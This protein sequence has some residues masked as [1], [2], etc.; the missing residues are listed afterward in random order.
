MPV[1]SS[2]TLG[3]VPAESRSWSWSAATATGPGRRPSR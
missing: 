1:G 3:D 2:L